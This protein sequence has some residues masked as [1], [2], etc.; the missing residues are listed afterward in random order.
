MPGAVALSIYIA[1]HQSF[2]L[3]VVCLC[4][5]DPGNGSYRASSDTRLKPLKTVDHAL[6]VSVGVCAQH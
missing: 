2:P 3:L 4:L 1:A 6:C 5:L